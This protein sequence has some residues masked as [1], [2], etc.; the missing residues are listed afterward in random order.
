MRHRHTRPYWQINDPE[1]LRRALIEERRRAN[2][3]KRRAEDLQAWLW[4]LALI[5]ACFI[6]GFIAWH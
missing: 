3:W 6:A 4:T 5:F 2:R 1:A